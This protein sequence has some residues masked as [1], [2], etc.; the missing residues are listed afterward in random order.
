MDVLY[1]KFVW[2]LTGKA[3]HTSLQ[4]LT[5]GQRLEIVVIRNAL[6]TVFLVVNLDFSGF[7]KQLTLANIDRFE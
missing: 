1:I 4:C 7:D 6:I 2:I 5:R 3:R